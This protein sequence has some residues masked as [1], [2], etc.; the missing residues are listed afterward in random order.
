MICTVHTVHDAVSTRLLT[1]QDYGYGKDGRI[2]TITACCCIEQWK[3]WA[4]SGRV[5]GRI[6]E[7]VLVTDKLL[8]LICACVR[9]A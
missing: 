7:L 6:L 8:V 1:M 3:I 2:G 5:S 4:L 9:V